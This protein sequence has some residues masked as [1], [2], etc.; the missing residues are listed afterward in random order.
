M[1]HGPEPTVRLLHFSDIH[2]TAPTRWQAQDWLS[3]RL[4][5]WLNWRAYR[6]RVFG[7]TERLLAAFVDR[8][9]ADPPDGLLFSGDATMLGFEA[10]LARAAE[11]LR[12]VESLPSVRLAV[13]GNHDYYTRTAVAAGWF[14]KYFATWQ[15]GK[16]IGEHAYPFA[17]QVGHLWLIG[18]STCTGNWR[19]TDASGAAGVPQ[20]ARLEQLLGALPAGPRILVTHYPVAQANGRPEPPVHGL[21]DLSALLAVA[22][23]GHV[24]LWLHGHRHQSYVLLN[25]SQARF[26]TVC[27]GSLTQDGHVGYW[28]YLVTGTHV[29]AHRYGYSPLA[30]AFQVEDKV[31]FPL[32]R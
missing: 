10:E 27:A 1:N 5:G 4:T 26:P 25:L 7:N 12:P 15:E 8:V 3:K 31:E 24:S 2:V 30:G 29:V 16:R 14:E 13:P 9:A 18:V 23:R 19:P 21:R 20:L 22:H 28:E 17:R 6:R 11:L 32:G